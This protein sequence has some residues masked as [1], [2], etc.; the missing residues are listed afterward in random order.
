MGGDG[1]GQQGGE[2][3]GR[4][5]K[6]KQ[7]ARLSNDVIN[8]KKNNILHNVKHVVQSTFQNMLITF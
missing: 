8:K 3:W 2:G 6:P 5:L 1:G 4:V 7:Y